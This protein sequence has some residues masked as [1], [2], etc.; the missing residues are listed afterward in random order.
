MVFI[1]DQTVKN[2]RC[3]DNMT[4]IC[5]VTTKHGGSTKGIFSEEIH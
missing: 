5:S 1:Y 2:Y 4:Y 3:D